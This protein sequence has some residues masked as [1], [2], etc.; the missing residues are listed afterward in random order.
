[1]LA[2]TGITET[3]LYTDDVERA[4]SFYRAVFE[5]EVIR[6]DE[7]LGALRITDSQ[8][9][10]LFRR[11]ASLQP[12]FLEGG[13]VPAHDGSGPLHVC[14]G[15][16]A[17]DIAAWEQRLSRLHVSIESRVRWPGGAVSLYFRDRDGHAVELATP[18]VWRLADQVS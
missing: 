3:C 11:G 12:H 7:R 14:F 6:Q 17:A 16:R 10:L 1:M 15:I 4:V 13:V 9:L 5:S 2:L 8:V 18:G